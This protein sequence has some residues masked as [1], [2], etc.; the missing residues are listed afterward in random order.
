MNHYSKSSIQPIDIM[1]ANFTDEQYEGFLVGNILKYTLRKKGQDTSDAKK[2][3][4][5][6][7][8]LEEYYKEKESES[9]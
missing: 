7:A 3:Q 1:R 9:D 4:V 2:I 6:A 5:Y 8:W